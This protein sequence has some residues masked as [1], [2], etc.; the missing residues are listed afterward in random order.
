MKEIRFKISNYRPENSY[1]KKDDNGLYDTLHIFNFARFADIND[2]GVKEILYFKG[3][4]EQVAYDLNG[5]EI[6]RYINSEVDAS[7][8]PHNPRPDSNVPIFEFLQNGSLQAACIRS[9]GDKPNLCLIDP[10]DGSVIKKN[11]ITAYANRTVISN[12][13]P[14]FRTSIIPIRLDGFNQPYSILVHR[15]YDRI[16]A[17]DIDLCLRWVRLIPELGHTSNAVDINGDGRECVY[18][19]TRLIDPDGVSIWD[20]PEWLN[21]SNENHCDSNIVCDLNGDGELDFVMATNCWVLDKNGQIKWDRSDLGLT[22]VQSVRLLKN[23]N[24]NCHMLCFS[25]H[26]NTGQDTHVIWRGYKLRDVRTKNYILDHNGNLVFEF[27]GMHTPM[28]GDWDGDGE[29]EIFGLMDNQ[30]T[31]AIYKQN[32]EKID[33]IPIQ[34]RLYV[35]DMSVVPISGRGHQ[36]VTHEWNEEQTE[37]YCVIYKNEN[38]GNNAVPMSQLEI[39]KITCY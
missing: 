17:Y 29:D 27:R 6:W 15:D 36:L 11:P 23:S 25:D 12:H 38:A 16:E 39:S 9:C 19:G 3:A 2:D 24:T 22:E 26:Y 37:T 32:G 10:L 31:I 33:E 8:H 18:T 5:N 1:F 35:S 34:N 20:H 21:L 30:I 13:R 7:D 14:E 28:V 4:S